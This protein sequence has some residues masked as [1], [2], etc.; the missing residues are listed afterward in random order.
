LELQAFSRITAQGSTL[1]KCLTPSSSYRVFYTRKFGYF[2]AFL[3]GVPRITEIETGEP[4]L[5]SE[6][7][8]LSLKTADSL[9]CSVAA[10]SSST[11]FWFW[12]VLSDCRNLNRRDILAFPLCPGDLGSTARRHLA[13][14]GNRYLYDLKDS[15]QFMKKSG[16][17]IET[18]SYAACKGVLDE[19]DFAL[20][21]IFE[22]SEH[23]LDF[24]VNYDIKYRIKGH[25]SNSGP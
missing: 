7:K 22:L 24:I 19:V 15:S 23:E 5:P 8:N 4:R 20:S 3:D 21:Q 25:S 6:L 14:L 12:N 13:S 17:E 9:L 1:S 10:L 11:F 2:L 16:L 18:F